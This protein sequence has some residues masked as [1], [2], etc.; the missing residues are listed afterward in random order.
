MWRSNVTTGTNMLIPDFS[1]TFVFLALFGFSL[2]P[3]RKF[4]SLKF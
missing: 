4:V 2:K 1:I 3:F